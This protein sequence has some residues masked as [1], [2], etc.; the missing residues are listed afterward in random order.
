[1]RW[2][3]VA[4]GAL[5]LA[6]GG[7]DGRGG[8]AF[9]LDSAGSTGGDGDG[10]GGTLDGGGVDE[11]TG[12][13]PDPDDG[14]DDMPPDPPPPM[15]DC[16]PAW[17]TPWIGSPCET[18]ADCS[19]D[20]GQCILES[21]GYPCGTCTLP[22]DNLCPDSDGTPETFC[23]DGAEVGID[24]GGHCLSKCDPALLGGNGCR[25]GYEC[26]PTSRYND[27]GTNAGVCLPML[28]SGN[29]RTDC[30]Q[31]LMDLGAVFVPVDHTP[32]HPDGHPEL[33][34]DI[35]EPVLLYSPINGVGLRYI[36][37]ANE[38]EVF[39]GCDAA[40]SIVGSAAVAADLGFEE[41]LHIGTYNCRVIAGTT[42]ISQHGLAN[43]I[44][45]GGFT[46]PGGAEITVLDDWEDGNPNPVTEYGQLLR[47]FTDQTWALGLWNIILTPEYNAA[48]DNHFHVDLTPGG[49]TYQ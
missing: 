23:V 17:T 13:S 39:V 5:A 32:D 28:Y 4:I 15:F 40:V 16:A 37:S 24:A 19:Y 48:H 46:L 10:G 30:Q 29:P 34:C 35:V 11:S 18:D 42:T 26:A 41:I 44:D 12:G 2:L 38:G 36:E 22:C 1:M 25:D 21:Q 20:G 7:D 8:A 27:P 45:I 47:A 9:E 43:A 49:N 33:T 6:C 3:W 31:T 14:G